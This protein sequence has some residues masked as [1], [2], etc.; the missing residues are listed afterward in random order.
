MGLVADIVKL[1]SLIL[2]PACFRP[3]LLR[4]EGVTHY[5]AVDSLW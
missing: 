3:L 4:L 5:P 2:L 1:S